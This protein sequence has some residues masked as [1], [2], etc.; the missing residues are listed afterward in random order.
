MAS[1]LSAPHMINEEAAYAYVEAR[2]WPQGPVCPHCGCTGR[3]YAIKANTEKRVRV[4]LKKCGDCR[5]QFTVKVGTIFE[6]SHMP[7]NLWLQAMFLMVSS[8]KGIS[9][10]QLHRT[11]GVTLKTAWFVGHRIREAMRAGALA[12]FGHGGGAVEADETYIGR[13]PLEPKQKQG[14]SHK[15]KVLT[16]VDRDTGAASSRV[17]DFVSTKIVTD[18]VNANL[19]KEAR[20]MTDEASV[21]RRVGATMAEHGHTVHSKGST[22]PRWTRPSTPTPSRAISA[23]SSAG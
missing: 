14:W 7:L 19:S 3:V 15:I 2:V 21:Y 1:A 20:L 13:D 23:S 5:K 10:Q 17:I 8:K 12:P 16:L 6:S 9:T 4:G 18:I 22:S 11:L